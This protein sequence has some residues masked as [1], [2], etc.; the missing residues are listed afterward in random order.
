MALSPTQKA[1]I[2]A[3]LAKQ[4]GGSSAA[5]PSLAPDKKAAID[6]LIAKQKETSQPT[7][8]QPGLVQGIVQGIAKPFLKTATNVL[9]FGEGAADL[10]QGKVG[11]ANEAANKT[12]DYG[13]FGKDI[14][15]VGGTK[16]IEQTNFGDFTKDVV[17]TG[18]E[19]GSYAA[20]FGSLPGLAEKTAA[21]AALEAGQVAKPWLSGLVRG[22]VASGTT[23]G[24]LSGAGAELQ[25]PESTVGSVLGAGVTS[26]L[27]GGV[28]GGVLPALGALGNKVVGG[29]GKLGSE[30]LGKSTGGGAETLRNIFENPENINLV[31]QATKEG[32]EGLMK[33]AIQDARN[34]LDVMTSGNS[35][36]YR[37]AMDRIKASPQDLSNA[38]SDI[39]SKIVQEATDGFGIRFGDG[40]KLNNLDFNASDVVEGSA[41]VQRAF[42][43]LFGEPIS[44]VAELDRVKKSLRRLAQGA[45]NRSPA[46][47]LIYKMKDAASSALKEK[48]PGYAEEMARFSEASDIADEITKAL[49]LGDKASIDTTARKLMSIM[50]QNNEL[51]KGMVEALGKA[52][53]EDIN[54]KIAGATLGSLT[55]RGLSGVLTPTIGGLGAVGAFLNPSAWP[56]LLLY[57]SSTS[58]RLVAEATA[59]MAKVKGPT[60]PVIIKQ[61]LKNLLIQAERE[62]SSSGGQQENTGI[63]PQGLPLTPPAIQQPVQAQ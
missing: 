53:G 59:L 31:R 41:S 62:V 49:S 43:R 14:A 42:D 39:R 15:P 35:K 6:A 28:T 29:A 27:L 58:P 47:A 24:V 25:K 37:E 16:P 55:P 32:P 44:S 40:K 34:G 21:K 63:A 50:R 33:S 2:D 48:V 60:V 30:V 10:L 9:N 3:V 11:Q 18:A 54:G 51:R 13:Y 20:P 36:A 46:Q 12:R 19:I 8:Q 5:S 52:G 57:L 45:P 1:Q 7:E 22:G 17:G 56:F 61:Q 23:S 26:G 4:K 38:V